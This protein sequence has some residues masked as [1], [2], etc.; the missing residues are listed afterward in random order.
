LGPQGLE[1][2]TSKEG[3]WFKSYPALY[4]NYVEGNI[5]H[6]W[7]FNKVTGSVIV[8]E[9]QVSEFVHH[10]QF[11][12]YIL[13]HLLKPKQIFDLMKDSWEILENDRRT[14]IHIVTFKALDNSYLSLL[15]HHLTNA[16]NPKSGEGVLKQ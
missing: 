7:A 16:K 5:N 3:R 8:N 1:N 2:A 14:H 10:F 4:Q 12:Y 13:F 15:P 9:Q 11:C 6:H